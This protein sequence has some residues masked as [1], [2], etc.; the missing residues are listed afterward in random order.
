MIMNTIF[1]GL[2]L[3]KFLE[4]VREL[5]A[6]KFGSMYTIFIGEGVAYFIGCI[7]ADKPSFVLAS[8]S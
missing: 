7:G 5:K 1:F 6:V 4:S 8:P 3:Y 2:T